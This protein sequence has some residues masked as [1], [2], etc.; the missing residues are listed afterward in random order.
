ME[1]LSGRLDQ[2]GISKRLA[3][4][5][6]RAQH[7][8]VVAACA[9]VDLFVQV[10]R[11]VGQVGLAVSAGEAGCVEGVA[12]TILLERGGCLANNGLAAELAQS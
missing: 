5:I 10:K 4:G 7:L 6:A 1:L 8:L 11:Q 3:A 12:D 9:K 2:H